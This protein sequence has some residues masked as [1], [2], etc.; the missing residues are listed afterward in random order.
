LS[1]FPNQVE[2]QKSGNILFFSSF[3]NYIFVSFVAKQPF[4]VFNENLKSKHFFCFQWSTKSE[5]RQK[6]FWLF[7]RCSFFVYIFVSL[8]LTNVYDFSFFLF[9]LSAHLF[10]TTNKKSSFEHYVCSFCFTNLYFLCLLTV[11]SYILR[12]KI[13]NKKTKKIESDKTSND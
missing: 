2:L 1:S 3:K 12:Q 9:F 6:S 7:G 10:Q 11:L 8:C 4:S 5:I 13:K